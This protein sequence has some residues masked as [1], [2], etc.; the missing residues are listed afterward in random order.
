MPK[1]VT[2]RKFVFQL[3]LSPIFPE[4]KLVYKILRN[5]ACVADV[6]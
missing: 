4:L 5:L 2:L 1:L 6:N 3:M